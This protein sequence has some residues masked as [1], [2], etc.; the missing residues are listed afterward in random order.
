LAV[1]ISLNA[2][3]KGTVVFLGMFLFLGSSKLGHEPHFRD[4]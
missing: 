2:F 1:A 4:T 3:S